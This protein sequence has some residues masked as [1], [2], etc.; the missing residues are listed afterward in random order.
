[1]NCLQIM[2]QARFE[3]DALRSAG[4][5]NSGMWID[6]EVLSAL[7][8][9]MART[10]RLLR[11]AGS[12]LL[13]KTMDSADSSVDFITENYDP[14]S[15]T[16]VADQTDYT[17]PPDF[18]RLVS[19]RIS[20]AGYESVT[21][22]PTELKDPNFLDLRGIPSGELSGAQDSD[23]SYLYT[24]IG[25]RTIRFAPAPQ[26]VVDVEMV[27]HYR[28]PRMRFYS[29]G[30]IARTIGD[31]TI[32]G[33]STLWLTEGLRTPAELLPLVTATT[34]VTMDAYYLT[35]LSI[36]SNTSLELTKTSIVTDPSDVYFLAMVPTLPEEHHQW[37]AQLTAATMLRKVDADLSGKLQQDLAMQLLEG[38]TPEITLRQMQESM[39]AQAFELPR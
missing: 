28:A 4:T 32:T 29:T 1:M 34:G 22:R 35:V 39:I 31:A 24:I 25:P 37:L 30:T 15:L 23:Q 3:V 36:D 20:T 26:D 18:V 7:N 6:E 10:A 16:W 8:T 12:E 14:G 27:Y 2:R 38:V 19:L 13:T 17:L 33:T 21:F 5:I 11:L 9:S